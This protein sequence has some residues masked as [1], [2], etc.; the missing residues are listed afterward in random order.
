VLQSNS[1]VIKMFILYFMLGFSTGAIL[2]YRL[3][4]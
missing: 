1:N 2:L 4:I 3:V